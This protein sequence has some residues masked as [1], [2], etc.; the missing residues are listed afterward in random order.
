MGFTECLVGSY[1]FWKQ[2]AFN[3]SWVPHKMIARIQSPSSILT[4]K[5]CP[6][7]YFYKY[8]MKLPTVTSIHAVR[9][10]IIHEV[11][12]EFFD[13]NV[14]PINNEHY[15]FE[16]KVILQNMFKN[17]WLLNEDLEGL[18]LDEKR[19]DFYRDESI[20]M[21]DNWFNNFLK[22]LN[23]KLT[24]NTLKEAFEELKPETEVKFV[25]QTHGIQGFID[26]IH[27]VDQEIHIIDYKTSNKTDIGEEFKL[28]LA[29]Y[30]MLYE[31]K[32]GI[33]P[34]TVGVDFLRTHPKSIEVDEGLLDFARKECE[35]IHQN[36][37]SKKIEDYP[38]KKGPLCKWSTGQCDFYDICYGQKQLTEFNQHNPEHHVN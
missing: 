6:R 32:Y 28:Q 15:E 29:I 13:L 16:L 36:T 1:S 27:K 18:A 33:K 8:V 22:R 14:E 26:A 4:H 21:L 19:L 17:K 7:K 11:L 12:E 30:A 2:K 20:L 34:K 3:E 25:S 38:L 37:L 31:E 9:G 5:Q 23:P 10:K 35:L 24:H